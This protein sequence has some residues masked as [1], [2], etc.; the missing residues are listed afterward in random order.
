[1]RI[2]FA[3][4]NFTELHFP[5]LSYTVPVTSTFLTLHYLHRLILLIGGMTS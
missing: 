3:K 2:E 5:Q 4:L 1:V